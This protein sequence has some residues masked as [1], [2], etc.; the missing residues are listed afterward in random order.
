MTRMTLKIFPKREKEQR[1]GGWVYGG[2]KVRKRKDE[3]CTNR[4]SKKKVLHKGCEKKKEKG[5]EL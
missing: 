4:G 5:C 3:R 2:R 1:R